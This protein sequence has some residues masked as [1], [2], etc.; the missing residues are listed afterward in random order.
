MFEKAR[1]RLRPAFARFFF[2]VQLVPAGLPSGMLMARF[3]P[4]D[5]DLPSGGSPTQGLGG[6]GGFD[7]GDGDFKKGNKGKL[8]AVVAVVA[9][10]GGGVAYLGMSKTEAPTELTVE[11]A[12]DRMKDIFVLP[13]EQQLGEWK[14]WAATP[15]DEGGLTEIKQEALKQLAW[16]RDPEGVG[17]ATAL[18]KSPSPKLQ[19]MA[20]TAL[21]H[22]GSPAAD[23]AK[24]A[25]IE[26][27]KTAGAGSKPQIGWALVVL[28][29]SSNFQEILTLYRSGQLASVQRLGGGQAFDPNKIVAMVP[30]DKIAALSKDESPSV[31]QLVA[32]VLSRNAAPQWT[33]T[34][35][36]LLGDADGDVARQAAPGLG[37]IG[38]QKARDPLIAKLKEADKESREKYLEALKNGAG[39]IGLVLSLYAFTSVEDEEQKWF[40]KKEILG[41]IDQLNDPR[42]AD[43][44]VDYLQ[45]ETH[46]HY[47]YRVARALAQIGDIR[48]VPM[49]AKRLR[50]DPEK[51][52]GDQHDWEM[53]LKNKGDEERVEAARM[54]SD[55]CVLHPDQ[56]ETV[57]KQAEDAVIFWNHE[58]TSPSA[59]GLRALVNMGSVK[60]L[61][62]MQEWADP[63]APLPKKGQ[64]PPMPEEFVIMRSALRYAGALKDKKSW[65]V[66]LDGLKKRPEKL[67]VSDESM[68][69]GGLAVLGESLNC[70]GSGASDGLSE[71]GDPKAFEPL[72][73]YATDVNNNERGRESAC[74]ALAWTA[75]GEAILKVAEKIQEF[76][77]NSPQDAFTR[78]CLL[79]TLVQRPVPGTASALLALLNKDQA[80]E[81]R[82]NVARAIAKSGIDADTESKLFEL[83]RDESL[84]N[85]AVLALILGGSPA[86]AARAIALYAD[87]PKTALE[88]VQ[89][90]WFRSFGFWSTDD[91]S[92]GVLFRYVD[93]AIAISHVELKATPQEWA[94]V[95]L[96]R[97]FETLVGDNGPHSFTRVVLRKR[98][99]D[100]ALGSDE[101]QAAAAVRTLRFLKE[102]G[103]LMTVREQ[104]TPAGKLAA[105]AVFELVN[106]KVVTGV[107]IPE[108]G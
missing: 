37:K 32:T 55:L 79:E 102:M 22:Y 89:D 66:L 31:R 53:E 94:P 82:N 97:Q 87:K 26:A 1:V 84:M 20:A 52:Y 41:L 2:P 18:L 104:T 47:Q 105:D 54:I 103:V 3:P 13:K 93:N 98:L 64:G 107:T 85:D 65:G 101:A 10:L 36:Q 39:G 6:S 44:L 27:L 83:A 11:Q 16:A 12:A 91:L 50:M 106:P 58:R 30:L 29:E 77:K 69:Q 56:L 43:A 9:A 59:N 96:Q 73:T 88:E 33:D 76:S 24:P 8:I 17:L 74:A 100:M 42:A 4:D 67:N 35:I 57:R 48:A 38:D 15:G 60:D 108:K 14:K 61:T 40:R 62:A 7:P 72:L 34:L 19:G 71:W 99:L 81:T 45:A 5:D 78:K 95:L 49:L 21:A 25:L 68:F 28:G 80:L 51:I 75:E 92:Q 46:V 63:K 86:A 70:F 23:A 90:L